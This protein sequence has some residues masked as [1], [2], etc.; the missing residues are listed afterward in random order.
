MTVATASS[1]S[2]G[3]TVEHPTSVPP[4]YSSPSRYRRLRSRT[5]S[6]PMAAGGTITLCTYRHSSAI[7][8][9]TTDSIRRS[10]T[11]TTPPPGVHL[12]LDLPP[13]A[14]QAAHEHRGGRPDI[15]ELAAQDRPAGLEVIPVGQQIAHPHHIR[16]RA[17]R[18]RQC[19]PDVPQTLLGLLHHVARDRHGRVVAPRRPGHVHPVPVDHGACVPDLLLE[20]RTTEDRSSRCHARNANRCPTPTTLTRKGHAFDPRTLMRRR[21]RPHTPS[22]TPT[23][24]C[25]RR[26]A[27]TLYRS[28]V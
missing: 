14:G 1:P 16:E 4:R 28:C 26:T 21:D 2:G 6:S 7:S 12:Y 20:G 9:P 15:A 3:R 18:L 19:G 24:D 10:V 25:R 17:L 22:P 5:S 27:W 11:V 13:R 23:T 8:S